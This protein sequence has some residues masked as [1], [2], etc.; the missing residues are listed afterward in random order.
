MVNYHV[1]CC[2]KQVGTVATLRYTAVG[3]SGGSSVLDSWPARRDERSRDINP[4]LHSDFVTIVLPLQRVSVADAEAYLAVA[5]M[6]SY[7]G[8]H[9]TDRTSALCPTDREGTLKPGFLQRLENVYMLSSWP[10][11]PAGHGSLHQTSS[12]RDGLWGVWC[13]LTMQNRWSKG[14]SAANTWILHCSTND[15]W[16]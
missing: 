7:L 15:S 9:R 6:C 1:Q 16:T 2:I 5:R 13:P 10:T 14:G 12:R 4:Q 11:D 8:D 3:V